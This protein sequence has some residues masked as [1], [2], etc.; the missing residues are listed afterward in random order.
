MVLTTNSSMNTFSLQTGRQNV[1]QNAQTIQIRF[2]EIEQETVNN[3]VTLS[4]TSGL[5]TAI[6][7]GNIQAIQ[8]ELLITASRFNFDDI[9]VINNNG[10]RL[11]D[12]ETTNSEDEDRLIQLAL[13]GFNASG[14]TTASTENGPRIFIS[15]AVPINNTSGETVGVII[16][17]QIVNNEILSKANIFPGHQNELVLIVDGQITASDFTDPKELEFFS[18]YLLDANSIEQALNGQTVISDQLIS[19]AENTP[20]AIGY[21]PLTIG[22]DTKAVIGFAANVAE[23]DSIKEQ[24]ISN[25]RAVFSIHFAAFSQRRNNY[26]TEITQSLHL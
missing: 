25:Q 16:G 18:P 8:A 20:H 6:S 15:A 24:L 13:L 9:D 11:F 22:A 1:A 17:S 14:L 7:T 4:N 19:N 26:Q 2:D 12:T 3:A 10:R 21:A 5:S 23:L